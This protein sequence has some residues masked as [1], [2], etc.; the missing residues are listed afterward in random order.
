MCSSFKITKRQLKIVEN[1]RNT[2]IYKNTRH[3]LSAYLQYSKRLNK[4]NAN[5]KGMKGSKISK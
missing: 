1:N 2:H 5:F 4:F 3:K